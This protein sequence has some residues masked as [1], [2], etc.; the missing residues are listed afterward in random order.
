MPS[1]AMG[2]S[3]TEGYI[4]KNECKHKASSDFRR[5]SS[6]MSACT[7]CQPQQE[8]QRGGKNHQDWQKTTNQNKAARNCFKLH[9][10]GWFLNVPSWF[11]CTTGNQ[12]VNKDT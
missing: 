10:G 8:V 2:L 6:D 7:V 3:L 1:V 11:L 12:P 9:M 4:L 5:M